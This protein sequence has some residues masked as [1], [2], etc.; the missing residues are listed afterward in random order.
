MAGG[1]GVITSDARPA[2]RIVNETKTG[3]VY[4]WADADALAA[5]FD[6][7]LDP[8]YRTQCGQNGRAAVRARYNWDADTVRLLAALEKTVQS[9]G[10]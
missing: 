3:E 7:M 6:R 8:E 5:A 1:L 10:G 4:H 2:A 9:R